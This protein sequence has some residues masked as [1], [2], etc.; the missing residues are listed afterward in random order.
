MNLAMGPG[1]RAARRD[2]SMTFDARQCKA[3]LLTIFGGDITTARLRA[4]R[5]VSR[6]RSSIRCRRAG[7]RIRRCRA[8]ISNGADEDE[9]DE[10]RAHRKSLREPQSRRLLRRLRLAGWVDP[11]RCQGNSISVRCS[12]RTLTVAEVRYRTTKE[13]RAFRTTSCGGARARP[14]HAARRSPGAGSVHGDRRA[15]GRSNPL[16]IARFRD[17]RSVRGA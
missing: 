15:A 17:R 7:P 12:G 5:V 8:A 6:W 9:V 10:A 2:G 11:R 14:D 4:E 16:G 3:P 13:G 1:A